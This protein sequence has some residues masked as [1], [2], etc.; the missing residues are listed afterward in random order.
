MVLALLASLSAC[1]EFPCLDEA[2][3]AELEPLTF[4]YAQKARFTYWFEDGAQR[5]VMD[6]EAV[7]EPARH[8]VL[9]GLAGT[10]SDLPGSMRWAADVSTSPTANATL[11]P[12]STVQERAFAAWRGAWTAHWVE[13]NAGVTVARQALREDAVREEAESD[14]EPS[15]PD[16]MRE[17]LEERGLALDEMKLQRALRVVAARQPQRRDFG[18]SVETHPAWLFTTAGCASCDAAREWLESNGV[19][20]H[21]LRLSDP[22]NAASMKTLAREAKLPEGA[23]YLWSGP[24][25]VAGFSPAAYSKATETQ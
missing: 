18:L 5:S 24:V 15:G 20:F 23:P 2:Q 21:E 25:V 19:G 6:R 13:V 7:P 16:M 9:V 12:S 10:T 3:S 17:E 14:P 4:D 22:S 11:A 8:A 1:S